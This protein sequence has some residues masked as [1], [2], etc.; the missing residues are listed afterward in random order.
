MPDACTIW[1]TL[2]ML[3][4]QP[5]YRRA[6][7]AIHLLAG[8]LRAI[9]PLMGR[10]RRF[11]S[12]RKRHLKTRLA[13]SIRFVAL[14]CLAMALI[15]L[16]TVSSVAV[17]ARP[18]TFVVWSTAVN[19]A[20]FLV[21]A[22]IYAAAGKVFSPTTAARIH[23]ENVF[24]ASVALVFVAFV[25]Q[26]LMHAEVVAI[27]RDASDFEFGYRA[28]LSEAFRSSPMVWGCTALLY[29]GYAYFAYLIYVGLRVTAGVPRWRAIGAVAIG[30]IA[31]FTY[32]TTHMLPWM[33][34]LLHATVKQANH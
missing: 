22:A 14:S 28:S 7:Q 24:Y 4:T 17:V 34:Q 16:L 2:R 18:E 11:H 10:P 33:E 1:Q 32:Q 19:L 3:D 31:L 30:T 13:E 8:T 29:A 25:T 6:L 9:G 26:P 27:L 12:L 15:F 21:I 5:L 20:H 23:I